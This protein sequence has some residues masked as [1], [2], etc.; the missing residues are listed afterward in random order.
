MHTKEDI[1]Q[2]YQEEII[3]L[4]AEMHAYIEKDYPDHNKDVADLFKIIAE[5]STSAHLSDEDRQQANWLITKIKIA[6][7]SLAVLNHSVQI[8]RIGL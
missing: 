1:Y 8:L 3:P 7:Y 4:M 6:A 5:N 2:T